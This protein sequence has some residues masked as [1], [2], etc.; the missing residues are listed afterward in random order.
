MERG[1]E[2]VMGRGR[3]VGREKGRHGEK[4]ERERER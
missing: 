3:V 1:T 2:V 4:K